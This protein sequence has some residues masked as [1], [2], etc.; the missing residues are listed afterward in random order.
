MSGHVEDRAALYALGALSEIEAA[1]VNAHA[2]GCLPCLRALGAAEREVALAA[3]LQPRREAPSA[4]ETRIDDLLA[5]PARVWWPS[6]PAWRPQAF[7]L[8]AALLLGLLPAAYFWDRSRA[9]QSAVVAQNAAMQ[10][11][12]AAPHRMASFDGMPGNAAATV[13]YGRT[14]SWYVIVIKGARRAMRVA[15]MHDGEQTMLGEAV[16]HGDVAMLY[17]PKSHRMDRLA[18]MDG[19]RVVARAS[20]RYD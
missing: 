2:R 9:M 4:L 6:A 11:M 1:A 17:L 7:A 10:R 15:W 8:A 5:P 18:L 12:I 16:P 14:G 19:D 20:L 13:A 3:S